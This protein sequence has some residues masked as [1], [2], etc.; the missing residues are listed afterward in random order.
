M[1]HR[2]GQRI[3]TMIDLESADWAPE[4]PGIPA[5]SLGTVDSI[6]HDQSTGRLM[7]YGVMLDASVVRL[8]ASMRPDEIEAL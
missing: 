2:I 3:R 5:G 1:A 8:A 4:Q 7:D 6:H